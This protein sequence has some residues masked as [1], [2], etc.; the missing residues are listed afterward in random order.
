MLGELRERGR[1]LLV[2]DNAENPADITGWLPGG[3][4]HVLICAT[5][6]NVPGPRSPRRSRWMCWQGTNRWRC[7]RTGLWGLGVADADRLAEQ[8]GDLPLAVAQ[9]AGFMS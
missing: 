8:L 4:G 9:A 3:G 2:V 7:C 5:T 1:W 6:A